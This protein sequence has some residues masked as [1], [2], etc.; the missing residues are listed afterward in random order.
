MKKIIEFIKEYWYVIGAIL[1]AT[2]VISYWSRTGV[3]VKSEAIELPLGR[4]EQDIDIRI[5]DFGGMTDPSPVFNVEV[6][7]ASGFE[8]FLDSINIDS[9]R[10]EVEDSYKYGIGTQ[11]VYYYPDTALAYMTFESPIDMGL[12][13]DSEISDEN[14]DDVI[15]QLHDEVFADFPEFRIQSSAINDFVYV[16]IDYKVDG[17]NSYISSYY[18]DGSS[19]EL[20]LTT[21][22]KVKRLSMLMVSSIEFF[23]NIPIMTNE[24][25]ETKISLTSF[26]KGIDFEVEDEEFT[27]LH[28]TF[29][30]D[31][32]LSELRAT[33]VTP[34]WVFFNKENGLA[35]PMYICIGDGVVKIESLDSTF[36]ASTIMYVS[37]IDPRYIILRYDSLDTT[38]DSS[39]GS[40]EQDQ[41]GRSEGDLFVG[42]PL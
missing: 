23:E 1:I 17:Y 12:S 6:Y 38:D 40:E 31:A 10:D 2:L 27:S 24:D 42:E 5:S 25:L 19:M 30:Q 28:P 4:Y 34:S 36:S 33:S 16:K 21:F 15:S 29:Q 8:S 7:D 26:P 11:I 39:A 13:L 9:T 41:V 14:I 18:L 32:Q 35:I 37:P 22:G 20:E 3:F